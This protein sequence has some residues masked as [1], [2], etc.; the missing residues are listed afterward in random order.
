MRPRE[1][2]VRYAATMS[3]RIPVE[4]LE[5]LTAAVTTVLS[6][7]ELE[8][9]LRRMVEAARE[10]TGARYAALGVIGEH[11]TL[12]EFVH[13]GI[14]PETVAMIGHLPDGR[15]VLGT[16]IREAETIRLERL[17]DHPDSVGF[18]EHH[19]RMD[20]FLGVPVGAPG[21][22]FGNL[23][24]TEKEGG[25]DED[26]VL[27]V[28]ALAAI[29]A[30][31]VETARLRERLEVMAVV[32]D[33]QRIGRD[34]H[35][36]IIQD[37]FGTGLQL[38]GLSAST[39]D[40]ASRSGLDEAVERIDQTIDAV[41]GIVADLNKPQRS[42]SFA[43]LL[44]ARLSRLSGPY[45][46]TLSLTVRP[47]DLQLDDDVSD[48]IMPLISEAVSNALRH[49]GSERVDVTVEAAGGQMRLVVVDQGV[50]FESEKVSSGMGLG[51]LRNRA[52]RLGGDVEVRSI[53]GVGTVVE[54]GFPYTG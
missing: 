34:L 5:L 22:A 27:V 2:P 4:R 39:T 29:A 23:Y 38:Q 18:P 33:R 10:A 6:A 14:P 46:V 44:R 40:E 49:S 20:S 12:V 21:E 31:A 26:D 37:L 28:E 42:G 36:S 30:T 9:M 16:L 43:E 24:L 51:N 53:P 50:G 52:T 11:K 7:T 45:E 15:G 1:K 48:L 41:R 17:S 47:P 54:V 32:E 13:T 19:P 3:R 35:D 25:F 8:T